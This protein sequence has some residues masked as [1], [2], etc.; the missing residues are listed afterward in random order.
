M[1]K[2]ILKIVLL[3]V[4]VVGVIMGFYVHNSAPYAIIK[5][6]RINE[7]LA[8]S[9]LGLESETFEIS[10]TDAIKLKGYLIK[11]N[12]DTKKGIIIFI[13][14]IGSCKEHGLGVAKLLSKQ[15]IE[16]IV[17]DGRAHGESDGEFTT[18]GF[19]EKKDISKIVD[20]IQAKNQN[21][22]IGIWGNSLGG[23]I[24]IQALAFDNRIKFG[25]IESTFTEMDQVV[26][27][28]SK[29]MMKGIIIKP[30]SDYALRRA[31]EIADF[32]PDQVK[33][34]LSVK[35]IQQPVLIAHGDADQ[36]ID[37]TYGKQLYESLKSE[38]KELIIVE[39]GG[40]VGL[41]EQG[42]AAYTKKLMAFINKYLE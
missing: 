31:G 13:H 41:A 32:D 3:I 28:Y 27:D 11:S 20:W 33:P 18:Y 38:D 1:L 10:A 29:K 26:Y 17:F 22:D 7:K 39:D 25:V 5:P 30:I 34:I 12:L 15:G 35:K 6:L 40:H 24:A 42:G 9:D 23:A 19:H 4:I 8:P 21:I 16:T 14:G 36:N 2:K 37:V